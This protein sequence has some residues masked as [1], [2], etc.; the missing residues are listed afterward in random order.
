MLVIIIKYL[1]ANK[2]FENKFPKNKS[3]VHKRQNNN[4]SITIKISPQPTSRRFC[5]AFHTQKKNPAFLLFIC[6]SWHFYCV[7]NFRT[8]FFAFRR[9]QY[10]IR[11][12][13]YAKRKKKIPSQCDTV[14]KR[15]KSTTNI[16]LIRVHCTVHL[17]RIKK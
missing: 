12:L 10:V 16:L 5:V 11:F 9:V 2:L 3:Q 13:L 6:K 14:A 8:G 4:T 1:R 15:K 17:T 7:L